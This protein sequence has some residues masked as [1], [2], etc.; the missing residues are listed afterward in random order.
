VNWICVLNG[1]FCRPYGLNVPY[2]A[3]FSRFEEILA[4]HGGRPHW[5]KAHALRPAELHTLYP[6]FTD[7]VHVLE[8][9]DPQ[10]RWRNEYVR[11]HVFGE[12]GEDVG[13]RVFKERRV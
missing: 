1:Y 10:G 11:R 6:R 8:E 4:Q 9:V 5:A 3:L 2:R 12:L 13:P 7:F